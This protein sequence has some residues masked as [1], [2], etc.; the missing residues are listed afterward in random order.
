M[1]IKRLIIAGIGFFLLSSILNAKVFR[2]E[3]SGSFF[4]PSENA[5]RNIY[6]KGIKYGLDISSNI[7]ENIELHIE[8]NYFSKKG[9]LTFTQE[10][11]R[12]KIVP[13][14]ANLRYIFLKKIMNFYAGAGLSY[15]LYEEKNP[16]GRAKQGKLGY[17]ARIG[18]FKRIKGLKKFIKDF[19]IDLYLNYHYCQMKP[20]EIKFDAGGIDL[21]LALGF[22]F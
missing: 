17:A 8:V 13:F 1:W 19:I 22:E 5:F 20:A 11:T 4:Y 16:I 9:K 6:G 7:R 18:G 10:S 2:I 21:G 15:D 3:I 14:G 12:V